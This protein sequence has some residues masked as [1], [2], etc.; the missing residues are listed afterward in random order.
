MSS[1]VQIYNLSNSV[2][3]FQDGEAFYSTRRL[4]SAVYPEGPLNIMN[5]TYDKVIAVYTL[6]N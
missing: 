1:F 5:N 4:G 3:E 2:T 6:E